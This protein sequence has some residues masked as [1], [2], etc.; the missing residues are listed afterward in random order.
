[1]NYPAFVCCGLLLL[2]SAVPPVSAQEVI[3]PWAGTLAGKVFSA[4]TLH[5]ERAN[6]PAALDITLFW[7][8]FKYQKR[9]ACRAVLVKMRDERYVRLITHRNC[10]QAPSEPNKKYL[11]HH[12]S[13]P[14][15][16]NSEA[17]LL[18]ENIRFSGQFAYGEIAEFQARRVRIFRPMILKYGEDIASLGGR[19]PA[20]LWLPDGRRGEAISIEQTDLFTLKGLSGD[21]P[22]GTPVFY[23][24]FVMGFVS[25]LVQKTAANGKQSIFPQF[26]ALTEQNGAGVF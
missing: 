11:L 6:Q 13:I 10:F 23:R 2:F 4:H 9:T 19:K 22:L 12:V 17:V 1:M 20:E 21:L 18:P 7:R 5:E 3:M 26:T 14:V 8:G 16:G 25:G 15:P 24:G